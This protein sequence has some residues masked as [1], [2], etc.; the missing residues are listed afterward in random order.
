MLTIPSFEHSALVTDDPLLAAQISALF[1]YPGR[2]LP[3]M[4]GPR[5]SRPDSDN[6]VVRRRNAL[7]LTAA[8]RVLMGG[9]S[10]SAVDGIRPGWK[11]CTV[12]DQYC[13]HLQALRG[14]VKRPRGSLRWGPDNLGV[15]V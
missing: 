9:L 3:V 6:E 10:S 7:A 5:M 11:N 8:R 4:D 15:G 2:Y 14:S 13:E 12:A 1:V